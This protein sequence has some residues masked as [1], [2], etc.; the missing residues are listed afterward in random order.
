MRTIWGKEGRREGGGEAGWARP[1]TQHLSTALR[2][3]AW[4]LAHFAPHSPNSIL[5]VCIE[6]QARAE[7]PKGDLC[8]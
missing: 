7:S 4:W 3:C 1:Y 6:S 5:V 8:T 2:L